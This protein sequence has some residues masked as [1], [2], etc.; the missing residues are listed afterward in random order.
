[1]KKEQLKKWRKAMGLTQVQMAELF[2]CSRWPIMKWE[3][4]ITDIPEWVDII[5][6]LISKENL[7]EINETARK[8]LS[9]RRNVS[10]RK[11]VFGNRQKARA[12]GVRVK[13]LSGKDRVV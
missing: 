10:Q 2:G 9:N 5:T 11:A 13:K 1:M 7:G 3:Q 8:A 4:G 6:R 12:K